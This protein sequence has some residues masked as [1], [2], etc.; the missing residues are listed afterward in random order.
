MKPQNLFG[1]SLIS[2]SMLFT[3]TAFSAEIAIA[4]QNKSFRMDGNKIE[5]ITINAGDTIRFN[6][7]DPYFHNIYSLSDLKTFDLGSFPQGQSK[8]IIFDKTGMIEVECA[9]HPEMYMEVTVQ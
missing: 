2:L 8:T 5:T 4:Q 1:A 6:N 7:E 3:A 9:I